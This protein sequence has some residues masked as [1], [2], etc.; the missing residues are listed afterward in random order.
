MKQL[1][2]GFLAGLLLLIMV[3]TAIIGFLFKQ[4]KLGFIAGSELAD[5]I[6]DFIT[7]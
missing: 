5:E 7:D 3:P 2:Q 6:N 4:I 1:I